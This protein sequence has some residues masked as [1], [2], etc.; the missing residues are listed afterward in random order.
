MKKQTLLAVL[1]T[2]HAAISQSGRPSQGFPI[3]DGRQCG[4]QLTISTTD[5]GRG[6]SEAFSLKD[7]AVLVFIK[8]DNLNDFPVSYNRYPSPIRFQ[9][10]AVRP[11]MAWLPFHPEVPLTKEE[12]DLRAGR[13]R[14]WGTRRGMIGPGIWNSLVSDLRE[15]H[16]LKP[17][18]YLVTAY[19]LNPIRA[20]RPIK[21]HPTC[22]TPVW[23]QSNKIEIEVQK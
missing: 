14:P 5:F 12:V 17:G 11:N 10:S 20:D 18:K 19:M 2:A 23:V 6:G 1:L 8:L 15:A 7:T 4:F 13:S 9:V 3:S 16:D 21:P 22:P